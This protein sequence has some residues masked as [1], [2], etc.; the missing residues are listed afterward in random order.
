LPPT[1]SHKLPTSPRREREPDGRK[2]KQNSSIF[3][4]VGVQNAEEHCGQHCHAPKIPFPL[5]HM[6][7][8]LFGDNLEWLRDTKLFADA[9]VLDG[10]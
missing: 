1:L 2:R 4:S 5:A 7:R 6:N 10:A 3:S 9:S 8:L